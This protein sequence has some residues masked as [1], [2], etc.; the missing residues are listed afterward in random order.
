MIGWAVFI[1]VVLAIIFLGPPDWFQEDQT[2]YLYTGAFIGSMIG[3]VLSGLLTD[4]MNKVMIHLNHGKYEPE[5]RLVLVIFQLIFSA[6]GLYGFGWT[7]NNVVKYHWLVLDVFFSFV[8]VGMVM[9]AV[10]ASLYIVDAHRKSS[11]ST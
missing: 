6:T 5:F 4:T 3:L 7:A 1:G 8:I 11:S 9:G 2:G 10:A